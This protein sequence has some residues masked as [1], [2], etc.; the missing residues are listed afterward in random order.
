M[1]CAVTII[2]PP[3]YPHSECFREVAETLHA[4]L[5]E[6]G[7]DCVLSTDPGGAG[8]AGRRQVVLGS[9][10][11]PDRGIELPGDAVLYNLEQ[12]YGGSPWM[13]PGLVALFQRHTVWDYSPSNAAALGAF[14]V[15]AGHVLPIGY[16]PVLT[17]IEP[18]AERDIDVLFVG[19]FNDRRRAVLNQMRARGLR[20]HTQFGVYG[21]ERDALIA[22]SK[23]VLNTHF[24]DAKVL[25]IVRISYLLA[26]RCVVL[27]EPGADPAESAWLSGGVAFAPYDQLAERA[28]SL[29]ADA[30]E[31]ARLSRG[32]FELMRG[33][34]I[35][36][37]LREAVASLGA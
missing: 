11:V 14:G 4:G 16:A 25:E 1:R 33:R 9:N 12:V 18:A 31:R 19:S 24:Y 2:S 5:V 37:M 34:P 26:N 7:H 10:L 21:R 28:V 20:V 35:A 32:G 3:G 15:R 23:V 6:L 29:V 8:M 22:R 17:R 13:T 30:A 36:P 27:S